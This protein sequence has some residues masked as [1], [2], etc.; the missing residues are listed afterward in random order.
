MTLCTPRQ[1]AG[2]VIP[3]SGTDGER[4]ANRLSHAWEQVPNPFKFISFSARGIKRL[5]HE[6]DA[7]LAKRSLEMLPKCSRCKCWGIDLAAWWQCGQAPRY[8]ETKM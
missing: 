1:I 7:E 3:F 8:T 2:Q 4:A 5:D 6:V